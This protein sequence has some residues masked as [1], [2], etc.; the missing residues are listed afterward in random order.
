MKFENPFKLQNWKF[1]KFLMVI[2]FFQLSLLGLF[3][4]NKLGID[5]PITRPLIG[6]IYL[7]FIPGYLL[8]RIL[9]LHKLSSIESFLYALGLSLFMDM[10]I[11]FLM[12][13]FYPM[14][15]ITN[16]PIAE[17][18]IILTMSGVV[19]LLCII[20]YFRDKEYDNPDFIDLRNI[21]NL[22]VLFSS[23]IPFMAIF[24]TYLVNY[25]H[26]NI[27]LM[28]MI[29]VIA[30]V[31]LVIGFT[32]WINYKTYPFLIWI[33]GITLVLHTMLIGNYVSNHDLE[34]S[35]AKD[36]I[37]EG[38]Y[39]L[40][41]Y[42]DTNSILVTNVF[43]PILYFVS[44]LSLT[45]IYKLI[46]P[47]LTS[48]IPLTTYMLSQK[49]INKKESFLSAFLVMTSGNGAFF[50][51]FVVT[52]K[53]VVGQLYLI[54]LLYT[55]LSKNIGNSQKKIIILIIFIMGILWSHYGSA[56]LTLLG[57]TFT[58]FFVI[59]RSKLNKN[60]RNIT[61]KSI[62]ISTFLIFLLFVSW[63]MNV[64][65][66]SLIYT[67]ISNSR[68]VLGSIPGEFMSPSSSRGANIV[69]TSFGGSLL[70][71]K[72]LNLAS[73]FFLGLGLFK[74][75]VYTSKS[76]FD[77]IYL[78]ISI[79]LF[80]LLLCS[81]ALPFF[82]AMSPKRLFIFSIV[83]C[84]PFCIQGIFYFFKMLFKPLKMPKLIKIGAY[85]YLTV[86]MLFNIGF[87]S[88]IVSDHPRSLPL[89]LGNNNEFGTLEDLGFLYSEYI[90][91][92]DVN[93]AKYL[94]KYSLNPK[95]K[96]FV[97]RTAI[98]LILV[99]YATI[100]VSS[101]AENEYFWITYANVQKNI[102]Y[103]IVRGISFSSYFEF[104]NIYPEICEQNNKIYDNG[105]SQILL[106]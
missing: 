5:T 67:L 51:I 20:A 11:G 47:F 88:E 21:L 91:G 90:C 41:E 80:T 36:V 8:L 102:G 66:S 68:A 81:V 3:A 13:I 82:S 10:F 87:V 29:A 4:L 34:M 27:L 63:Y 44:S 104:S 98:E 49:Y 62:I 57:L 59:T 56:T 105:G 32:N 16:K 25:Y 95:I 18:P 19:F 99:N 64:S 52:T 55:I 83:I 92:Y 15:G 24:G 35:N 101:N 39:N 96:H 30:L 79:Y 76:K 77:N 9:K 93:S 31:V 50:T 86:L 43:T 2:L 94:A 45:S 28:I 40:N 70:A 12:N 65:N 103:G 100:N 61:Q 22:Q 1:K 73:A 23:L 72:Y 78:G 97:V 7:S 74:S 60:F 85:M 37:I 14:F 17:I 69:F 38:K 58:T 71:L 33:L 84:A 6:F 54:L 75:L 48:L 53:Q 89:L 106:S 46:F 42:G 26:N